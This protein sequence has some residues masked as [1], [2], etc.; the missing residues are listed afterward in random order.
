MALLAA[1]PAQAPALDLPAPGRLSA[2]AASP[3]DT[4][5]LATGPWAEGGLPTQDISG[6]VSHQAWRMP[7][8][9][10]TPLQ[11][12]E[13]IT[14]QLEAEGFETQFTCAD[15]A[16]GG[17]DFRFALDLL[18]EPGMH[19]NL[20]DFRY[21][22]AT[23][24]DGTGV[25][26]VTSR[27]GGAG[28][29]QVSRVGPGDLGVRASL[30]ETPSVEVEVEVA[31][32]ARAGSLAAAMAQDGHAVL[33]DLEFATGSSD[34]ADTAFASLAALAEWLKADPTRRVVLVGHSDAQGGLDANIDLS[35]QRAA[36]VAAR[37]SAAHGIAPERLSAQGVGYLAPVASNATA[38]GRAANRRVDAV[39]LTD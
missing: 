6:P 33:D 24:A 15:T 29:V 10:L 5:S 21:L 7:E 2:E 26:V 30:P 16:C 9:A 8:T 39:A 25:A 14:A 32:P 12:L 27:G 34:L 23:R 31:A 37:L 11:I 19:V 38:E 20:G 13:A 35:R 18:P 17:F 3:G 28:Y 22:S 1:L 36:S 4:L